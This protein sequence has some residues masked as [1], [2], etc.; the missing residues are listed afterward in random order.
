MG[1][2]VL[3]AAAAVAV[4]PTPQPAQF[5]NWIVACDNARHCEAIGQPREFPAANSGVNW[6]VHVARG[7]DAT[8]SADV[9]AFPAFEEAVP[10][11]LRID[12]KTSRFAFGANGEALGDAASLLL[13]LAGARKVEAIDASGKVVGT[14]PVSGA[15]A[16]LRWM[17]DRQKR[18]GTVSALIARGSRP[19]SDVPPPPPLPRIAQ[20]PISQAPA[21]TLSATYLRE[22]W[23]R[24][25]C[26]RESPDVETYRLDAAHSVGIVGCIQGAYQGSSLVVVIDETGRW[27]PA[28]IEQPAPLPEG[29]EPYDAYMLTEAEYSDDARMLTMHAK[30]RGLADCGESASWVWDGKMFRLA[31]YAA[32]EECGGAPPETWLSR[33]QTANDP[34]EVGD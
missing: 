29:A 16:A 15:S 10:V 30:G 11:R 7:A 5:G 31:S 34:L 4:A 32:L 8:A 1:P 23:Q 25:D 9:E 18:V 22:I 20:P 6:T 28:P 12:G 3:V 24:G 2:F 17:D 33:W 21:R 26:D 13:A 27:R 19:A 14:I